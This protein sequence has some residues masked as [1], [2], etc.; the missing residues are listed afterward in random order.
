M[1]PKKQRSVA[2]AP[3][4][5]PLPP[6]PTMA[7]IYAR[8][9]L[10]FPAGMSERTAL[11]RDIAAKTIFVMFYVGAVEGLHRWVRPNQVT[12]MSDKQTALAS[13]Q[14]REEW[15]VFS[16]SKENNIPGR[17]FADNTREPIRDETIKDGFVRVGA[18]VERPGLPI[19]SSK[20]RY[21]LDA[22]FAALFLCDDAAFA[23]LTD[24]W[25]KK[26]LTK[27]ALSR[28]HLLRRNVAGGNP[29]VVEVIFPNG[30]KRDMSP[31][32]SSEITKAVVEDFAKRYL[33][34]PGVIWISE[35]REKV[36]TSDNELAKEVGLSIEAASILPDI[37]L[38]DLGPDEPILVFVEVVAT[39]GPMKEGRKQALI[40]LMKKGGHDP[41]HAAFVTAFSDRG[42]A[43]YRKASSEIAWDSFVWF[44]SEP[45]KIVIHRE[46]SHF[47]GRLADLLGS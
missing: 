31:G 8:L 10:V 41:K 43:A 21:A 25:Q 37:I 30:T 47:T 36:I 26:H 13:D 39:D 32:P 22:D 4:P 33:D 38:V 45:D 6:L 1:T 11:V 35:S 12:R 3:T 16:M 29:N 20:P 15:I 42:E 27:G 28:L 46:M 17:W 40:A 34:T 9:P 7:T 14:A 19:T 18:I 44:A 5:L 2:D 24:Q 23:A